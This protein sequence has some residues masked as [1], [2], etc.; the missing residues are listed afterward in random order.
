[1]LAV[2]ELNTGENMELKR[3]DL[4]TETMGDDSPPWA[5]VVLAVLPFDCLADL[6]ERGYPGVGYWPVV[7]VSPEYD[8]ATQYL[9]AESLTVD[10]QNQRVVRT[11]AVEETPVT[12]PALPDFVPRKPAKLVLL[13]HGHLATLNAYFGALPELDR[14]IALI[15]LDDSEVYHRLDPFVQ[16]MCAV[17]GLAD[18]QRDALFIEAAAS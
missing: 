5:H 16:S 10:A 8:A 2:S 15:Q 11:W 7:D 1:M 18:D 17:L 14:T 3:I 13:K 12:P 6:T 9:G 4:A